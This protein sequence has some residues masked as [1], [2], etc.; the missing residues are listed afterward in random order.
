MWESLLPLVG[1]VA[2]TALGGPAGGAIGSALG[3][4]AS[5]YFGAQAANDANAQAIG[6]IQQGTQQEVGAIQGGVDSSTRTLSD[7][8]QDNAPGQTYLRNLVANPGNLTPAQ[9]LQLNDVNRV[10]TNQI[11][12]SSLAGSGRSAA[13]LIDDA[14]NRFRLGALDANRTAAIGAASTMAGNANRAATQTAGNQYGGGV[15]IGGAYGQ[16]GSNIAKITQQ[17]GQNTGNA[18][19]ASGKATGTAFGNIST[20]ATKDNNSSYK[21]G[22]LGSGGVGLPSGDATGGYY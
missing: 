8:Q 3:S 22:N 1:G 9:Q 19:L 21:L 13:A 15:A 10:T 2:G 20:Q 17:S 18:I 11:D 7:V 5:N 14:S 4:A 6:Q 16:E 12:S